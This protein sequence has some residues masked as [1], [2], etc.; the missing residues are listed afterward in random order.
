M[1]DAVSDVLEVLLLAKEAG[2]WRMQRDGT[3]D[4]PA[5]RRPAPRDDRRPGARRGAARHAL[6][7]PGLRPPARRARADAGGDARLLGLQQGRRLLAGELG[8]AQ[9]AGRDRPR[10]PPLRASTSGSSTGAAGP[11]GAAAGGRTR[12]SARCR[13]SRRTAASA[14][15]S[16][17]RSSR[18]ATRSPASPGATSNRSSTPSSAP[19]PTRRPTTPPPSRARRT[20]TARAFMEAV[21]DGSMRAYRDLIDAPEFWPW[22]LA[23][24]PIEH[25]AGLPM[26]SRPDLAQGRQRGRLRRAP[27]DPVGVRVDAAALRPSPAGTASGRPSPRRSTGASS[28]P[29][30]SARST[31]TWPFFQAVVANAL[32]EMARARLVIAA[33][34]AALADEPVARADRRRVRADGAGAP[35]RRRAGPAARPQ[36]RHREVD[37]PAQP[38]HR[39]AQPRP[40]RTHAALAQRRSD[41]RRRRGAARGALRLRQRHRRR[42]AEHGVSREGSGAARRNHAAS[43]RHLPSNGAGDCAKR[44][45]TLP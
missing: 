25:I 20:T 30:G 1:T 32:R 10:L 16:R 31:P 18:S 34:Y 40:A 5:R 11:S 3:V 43:S 14:S 21:A 28:T 13:P 12:P 38:V 17:A 27:G 15:P 35:R 6:Q 7:P 36:P 2:L 23:A 45:R 42:D 44:A 8:A 26:A 41:G 24:T 29:T 33:R 9:S 4:V 22:Y 19:S 39:R 37:P